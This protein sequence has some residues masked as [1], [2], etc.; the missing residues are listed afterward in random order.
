MIGV[1]DIGNSRDLWPWIFGKRM[2][3]EQVDASAGSVGSD[4]RAILVSFQ[5]REKVDSVRTVPAK[6]GNACRATTVAI[7]SVCK[8]MP[9]MTSK[10]QYR[11]VQC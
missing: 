7:W 10:G 1:P 3:P 8:T 9:L 4:L 6:N 2:K 5:W 11:L